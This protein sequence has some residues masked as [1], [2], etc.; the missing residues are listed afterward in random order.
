[1]KKNPIIEINN[2][3]K[4]RTPK[5]WI[6]E[7]RSRISELLNDHANCELKAASTAMGFIYKYS[8][9]D[10]LCY[11]MSRIAREELRHFEQVKSLM[12]KRG[13]TFEYVKPSKY[14]KTLR[15]AIRKNE[16]ERFMDSL[17][18]G[19]IIEARS[20]ERFYYLI[21]VLPREISDFYARLVESES[22]HFLMYLDFATDHNNEHSLDF[23]NKLDELL[24]IESEI[25]TRPDY[26]FGFHSGSIKLD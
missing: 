23:D 13:T 6:N 3:L 19:A 11:R 10:N 21:D 2:F 22:R 15:E 25:I 20:C 17:I 16:P 9:F 26:N 8:S 14:A 1:M 12:K 4:I 7:A 24:K 18:V 5:S